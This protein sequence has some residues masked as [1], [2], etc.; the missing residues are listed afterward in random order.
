MTLYVLDTDHVSLA[1]RGHPQVTARIAAT[2]PE[3]LTV[4]IVTV[5]EQLRGRLAQ[6]Q[7]APNTAALILAYQRLHETLTF[8]LT[9][10]IADFDER[11][12]AILDDLRQHRIR[13]S[14][15]DL[16]IAAIAL[17]VG[18]TLVTR[19]RRDFEQVPGLALEDWSALA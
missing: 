16:R 8:Y 19:N 5:Q 14:T 15:L 6:V 18:A 2:P 9:V 12:A 17:A 11:A 13:I 7:H 3:Q 1:Q 4:S 10:P